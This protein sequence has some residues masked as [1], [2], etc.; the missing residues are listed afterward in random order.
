MSCDTVVKNDDSP[1]FIPS[2]DL[3]I[4]AFRDMVKEELEEVFGFFFF[5]SN[6]TTGVLLIHV[7]SLFTCDR[8]NA[9]NWMISFYGFLAHGTFT[10]S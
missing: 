7:Q 1:R 5:V 8:M 4:S 9:D 3:E 6:D 2:S 10:I